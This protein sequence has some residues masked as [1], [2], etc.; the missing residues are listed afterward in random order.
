MEACVNVQ[1]MPE[2]IHNN[3]DVWLN[4]RLILMV[5]AEFGLAFVV[6]PV[7]LQIAHENQGFD[8]VNLAQEPVNIWNHHWVDKVMGLQAI[9]VPVLFCMV[10]NPSP[11]A[12]SSGIAFWTSLQGVAVFPA[13]CT[14]LQSLA[15]AAMPHECGP[16]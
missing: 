3:W 16:V 10:V 8:I 2:H 14:A 15:E 7:D 11:V 12:P 6:E 1:A 9:Q 13:N 5:N 4:Q